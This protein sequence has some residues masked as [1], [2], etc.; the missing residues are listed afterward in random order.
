MV[1]TKM[2][3]GIVGLGFVGLSLSSV[4]ASKDISTIGID[5]DKEKCKMIASGKPPFF[6]PEL[7]KTLKEGLSKKFLVSDDFSLLLDCEL[8]FVT[9]GTP[10]RD[11]GSIELGIIKDAIRKISQIIGKSK[12]SQTVIIKSTVVP[13]TMKN[14]ILPILEKG[15]RKKAG[16]EFGLIS[17]PEF[18]QESSAIKNTK[19]PHLIILGGYQTQFMRKFG[20][21]LTKIHPNTKIVVTN[22]QTA[23]MIKYANNSFLA[24]K[25]SFINQLS[26][27][28]QKIP[29]VNVDEIAKAIGL[30]P[31]IGQQF[32]NAGPGYGGSCLP[33]DM[34]A[35]INFSNK[36]GVKPVLLNAVEEINV[37]QLNQ[38]I[39]LLEK[40]LGKINSKKITIFGTSFKP[41]TDDVRDSIS[42]QLIKKLLKKKANIIVFDPRATENTRKIFGKKISYA[43]S[44]NNALDKSQCLIIMTHWK[45]FEKLD[46]KYLKLMSRKLII[47]SRRIFTNRNLDA[48]Y[49][50]LGLGE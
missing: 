14:V 4:L 22:H 30:D 31:R 44:M 32:L 35:L 41:N 49:I 36:V 28:C 42:I 47:D 11:D 9:V 45:Q 16:K 1:D 8:I 29:E 13:G 3:V 15:S 34:K 38:I 2:R 46:Q 19:F 10:Q 23:E 37:K 17:N 5:T 33:K 12:K 24:T 6:E 18:L 39:S 43:N 27:I 26:N 50:A 25:I 20:K 48:E 7:E 40:K 21:F